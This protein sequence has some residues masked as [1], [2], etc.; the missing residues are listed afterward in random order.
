M[1]TT[2]SKGGSKSATKKTAARKS[3]PNDAIK[4]LEADH[5]Q[6]DKWFAE[7]EATN[8]AKTKTKLV[9]QICLALKVHTQIEE[10]IFYP[11]S[12]DVLSTD[13]EDMVDEAV[14]EHAA[15]KQLIAELEQMEVG[16]DL[17]D[18][19]VKVLQEMI[20]HH[21]EEEEKDYFPAC[22]KAGMDVEAVGLQLAQRKEELMGQMTRL[23]GQPM[24]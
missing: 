16:E 19:K 13:Q 4:L 7:F 11:A 17:Y 1:A 22:R 6:V 8:G 3:G 12:R 20:E 10:E 15:A 5:R 21:V 18:A 2:Q 9:E 23:N 14:V 24:Q